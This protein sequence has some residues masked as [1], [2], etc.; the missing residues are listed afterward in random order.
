M[1]DTQPL[2]VVI[3]ALLFAM[4]KGHHAG[5]VSWGL[6]NIE[7]FCHTRYSFNGDVQCKFRTQ[8]ALFIAH[9]TV[10]GLG[11]GSSCP[12]E[13]QSFMQRPSFLTAQ[14]FPNLNC[15]LQVLHWSNIN[16]QSMHSLGFLLNHPVS[17]WLNYENYSIF[18][19]ALDFHVKIVC[20]SYPAFGF[21]YLYL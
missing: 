13:N 4:F 14:S 6:M 1:F 9:Q 5:P 19:C 7:R 18:L 20:D 17:K 16:L 10:G 2:M 8:C 12:F 15:F 21:L 11:F 3:W